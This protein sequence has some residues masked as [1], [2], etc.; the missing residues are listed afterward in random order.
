MPCDLA[1][2]A[3]VLE[4]T[5]GETHTCSFDLRRR[6]YLEIVVEQEGID[7]R[8]TLLSPTSHPLL[9]MDS[10]NGPL[11]PEPLFWITEVDGLHTLQLEAG[12]QHGPGQARLNASPPRSPSSE[13][14]E[15]VQALGQFLETEAQRRSSHPELRLA[16]RQSY[17]QLAHTWL[18]LDQPLLAARC[19]RRLGNLAFGAG[20]SPEAVAAFEQAL[21]LYREH[22]P[23]WELVTQ[24]LQI[25]TPLR[26]TSRTEDARQLLDEALTRSKA[27]RNPWGVA[28]ALNNQGILNAFLGA[29]EAALVL[30]HQ[31]LR[32]WKALN[33][34]AAQATTSHNIGLVYT[35]LGRLEDALS[36]LRRA[37]VL[38]R[39]LP[40]SHH[41][42]S[43]LSATGWALFLQGRPQDARPFYNEA[44]QLGRQAND[45]VSLAV[46]LEYLGQLQQEEGDWTGARRSY[47]EAL[48]LT[49][50]GNRL[51]EAI[52]IQRLGETLQTPPTASKD[53]LQQALSLFTRAHRAFEELGSPHGQIRCLTALAA[54]HRRLDDLPAAEQRL[55]QALKWVEGGRSRITTYELRHAFFARH[56]NL[57][58]S[59][60][61]HL[62]HLDTLQPQAGHGT[63]ALT[64]SERGRGRSLLD[65]VAGVDWR[66][67]LSPPQQQRERRLRETLHSHAENRFAHAAA[68]NALAARLEEEKLLRLEEEYRLLELELRTTLDLGP[69]VAPGAPEERGAAPLNAREIQAQLDEDTVMLVLHWGTDEVILWWVDAHQITTHRLAKNSREREHLA[70]RL[71]QLLALLPISHEPGNDIPTAERAAQVSDLL[72]GP[73]ASRLTDQ[74]LVIVADG[75]VHALPFAALPLPFSG[76]AIQR[77][78]LLTHHELVHLPSASLLA[79]LT[80][81]PACAATREFAVLDDP[82]FQPTD[83]RFPTLPF[84]SHPPPQVQDIALLRSLGDL[85]LS[86]L[87]RLTYS[88]R[89]ARQLLSLLPPEIP[90]FRATGFDAS[91]D[92]VLSGALADSR[93]VH[94]ATHGLLDDRHPD[95]S[96]LVLSLYDEQGQRRDGFLRGRDIASL[97]LCTELV[98]LSA[99]KTALAS[100]ARGE[101]LLGLAH[102]FFLA[103]ARR[104]V[105]SYWDVNDAATAELMGHFYRAQW[106]Q[107]LPPAAALR[108]AQ[109]EMLANK[110]FRAPAFWAGFALQGDWHPIRHNIREDSPPPKLDA[111]GSGEAEPYNASL[112]EGRSIHSSP[113]KE[114]PM[115][116]ENS[117]K[118]NE[119]TPENKSSSTLDLDQ[120]SQPQTQQQPSQD[121]QAE[122]NPNENKPST[123]LEI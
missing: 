26:Y 119:T 53:D 23:G 84:P 90:H 74:R 123:I 66:R 59:L 38:R 89:E 120:P 14:R 115:R 73:V 21:P 43:T 41:L 101:G 98:V 108:R 37:E 109:L 52:L 100:D 15:R 121:P 56:R 91:R 94:F 122:E 86:N 118:G 78:H 49:A 48:D 112:N 110:R 60:V 33:D 13:D 117:T 104:L 22:D 51:V 19:W 113:R 87:D 65:G 68:G 96:G 12:T 114:K 2:P 107:G 88:G 9:T 81:R 54:L 3:T 6:D 50:G 102:S 82:V 40:S 47:E 31:A 57:F 44:L 64:I 75:P 35:N 20:K 77:P 1:H 111:L 32:Q 30:Y 106:K 62:V 61:Q 45:P 92:T 76:P 29:P 24:L 85:G 55:E 46:T 80:A 4:F 8:V 58:D 18:R 69:A 42:A 27:L 11:G 16:A 67:R 10:P 28:A 83:T 116:P 39:Q 70:Q 99:C 5:A 79:A 7:L 95:L 25:S 72:L 105:A 63:R 36:Y 97:E 17:E 34:S 71:Q 103:G 93:R